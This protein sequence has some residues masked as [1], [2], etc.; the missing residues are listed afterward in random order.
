M[1]AGIFCIQHGFNRCYLFTL[2]MAYAYTP[3]PV[4]LV[5]KSDGYYVR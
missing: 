1:V 5:C 2:G 3:F 4:H